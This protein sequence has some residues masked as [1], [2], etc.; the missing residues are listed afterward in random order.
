MTQADA[1]HLVP[2]TGSQ[3]TRGRESPW[4]VTQMGWL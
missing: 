2:A 1:P 4:T 3:A